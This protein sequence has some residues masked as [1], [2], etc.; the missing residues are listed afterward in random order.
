MRI[1]KRAKYGL[2]IPLFLVAS[3]VTQFAQVIP[4]YAATL[5]WTGAGDG[6]TFADDANW[7]TGTAPVDGDVIHFA[8]L[9]SGEGYQS[10][11]L[12]NDL[13]D[14]ELAGLTFGDGSVGADT[15]YSLDTITL[16][17]NASISR[18]GSGDV[19]V[20][21]SMQDGGTINALGN[22]TLDG[23][24]SYL[25]GV[26]DVAGNLVLNGNATLRDG[27]SV[28]GNLVVSSYAHLINSTVGGTIQLQNN[29][30][31]LAIQGSS[32]TLSN[33]FIVNAFD[34]SRVL[35]QLAFGNCTT[36]LGGG[37]GGGGG[38]YPITVGCGTYGAATFTLSG[39]IT[40]NSD[41]VI[42][43]AQG[44]T[45]NITGNVTTNGHEIRKEA[46]ST[47]TLKV[48]GSAVVVPEKTT[49]L[50][51]NQPSTNVTVVN[52]E[53]AT[54]DGIR[55]DILVNSGGTLKGTGTASYLYNN[56]TVNPGNSPG[57]LTVLNTYVQSGT[58]TPEILH[59]DTYDQ[60]IV[61]EDYPGSGGNAVFL[62]GSAEL[63]VILYEGWK[64]NKGD[65]FTI[66][67]N[68]SSTD[69]NGTFNGLAEGAQLVVDGI[70]FSISY[71]GG[72]GNDIVLT[73]LN[74][75]SDPNTPNT[76]VHRFI[77]ANPIALAVLGLV[78]ASLLLAIAL[79]RKSTR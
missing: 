38:A 70:T 20:Y 61:G 46:S 54:L 3:V 9:A 52:K 75:G 27:S 53:T 26:I 7:S 56:G 21:F 69:I 10:V 47:G 55:G 77:A 6:T 63:D 39:D 50:S 22:L 15:G 5:T 23:A 43:V 78:S 42:H 66:I 25:Y 58:Y 31:G 57:T 45:V 49:K 60:L 8:P 79:R 68:R 28:G 35:N 62:S 65:A 36:P 37:S 32:Q 73:A 19:Y 33:D 29:N 17:D 74:T 76:G 14:V 16:Q 13:V 18:A 11:D 12:E 44:S 67:D 40:L 51:G 64:I 1:S 72:D 48:G 24:T 59:K 2:A 71:E 41:L 4:T 30:Q 34:S